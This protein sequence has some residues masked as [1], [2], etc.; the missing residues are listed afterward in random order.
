MK[1][2]RL[3]PG[4]SPLQNHRV[5]AANKVCFESHS[6][7]S[8]IQFPPGRAHIF[9]KVQEMN[10]IATSEFRTLISDL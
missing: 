3:D 1:I 8:Q 5:I 6:Y 10:G 4:T 2:R 9:L 7:A